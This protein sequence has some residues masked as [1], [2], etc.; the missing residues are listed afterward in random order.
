MCIGLMCGLFMLFT[1]PLVFSFQS[2]SDGC[3]CF[4]FTDER[5]Q[6]CRLRTHYLQNFFF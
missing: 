3:N 2:L 4:H 6:E 5:S 1:C